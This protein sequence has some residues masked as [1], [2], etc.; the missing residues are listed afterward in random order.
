MTGWCG[1]ASGKFFG[2]EGELSWKDKPAARLNSTSLCATVVNMK[3]VV[4]C[5]VLGSTALSTAILLVVSVL[6]LA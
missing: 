3:A 1:R 6:L 2:G 5:L 4:P